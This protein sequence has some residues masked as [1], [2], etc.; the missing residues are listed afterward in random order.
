TTLLRSEHGN[1]SGTSTLWRKPISFVQL[2]GSART[3]GEQQHLPFGHDLSSWEADGGA[4]TARK[5]HDV[6]AQLRTADGTGGTGEPADGTGHG[7]PDLDVSEC[8]RHRR[9]A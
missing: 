1:E 9:A 3:S 7:L 8:A 5:N 2:A 4:R 6:V